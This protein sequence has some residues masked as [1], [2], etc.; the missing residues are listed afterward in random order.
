MKRTLLKPGKG[1]SSGKGFKASKGLFG[2]SGFT[3]KR[4]ALQG[5]SDK[6]KAINED[7]HKVYQEMD[8]KE[9]ACSGCGANDHLEHSHLIPRSKRRDLVTDPRNI[10]I[11]CRTCHE[12]WEHGSL[13]ERVKLNDF[14]EIMKY[15]QEVDPGHYKL[16]MIK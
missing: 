4:K 6:Q 8:A 3:G 14:K 13:D 10:H 2:G 7:L 16:I 9:E 5:R 12:I 1:L 11:H 15:I